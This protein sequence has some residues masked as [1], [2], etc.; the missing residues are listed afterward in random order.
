MQLHALHRHQ[1]V[2]DTDTKIHQFDKKLFIGGNQVGQEL[3]FDLCPPL[4]YLD[5]ASTFYTKRRK[6]KKEEGGCR[7]PFVLTSVKKHGL[8]KIVVL[9]ILCV[10]VK[11]LMTFCLLVKMKASVLGTSI[12]GIGF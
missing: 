8:L 6:T 10:I 9:Y 3:L 4:A 11:T 7:Y 12:F 2:T 5:K 1:K